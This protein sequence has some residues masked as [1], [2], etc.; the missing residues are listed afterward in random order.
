MKK[1]KTEIDSPGNEI[2]RRHRNKESEM[3]AQD[4]RTKAAKGYAEFL[5]SKIID[6][7]NH[8]HNIILPLAM[9]DDCPF[10]K[11][12]MEE[13]GEIAFLFNEAKNTMDL[14]IKHFSAFS[15]TP[16]KKDPD[17]MMPEF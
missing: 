12:L 3:D 8:V 14:L 1:T 15:K 9:D 2:A 17:V 16:F 10:R 7:S 13:M 5:E 4:D 11:E 6:L